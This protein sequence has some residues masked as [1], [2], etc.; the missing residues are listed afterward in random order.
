MH[1][2]SIAHEL[3]TTAED[4]MRAAGVER[5]A[6]VHLRLGAL[7]GVVPEAL[8]FAYAIA[9]ERTLLAGSRLEIETAPVVVYCPTCAAERTLPSIQSFQ[10][11]V[12]AT[13]TADVRQ[14]RE[15]ELIS[16]ECV[17]DETSHT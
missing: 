6:V 11:P 8:L 7:S 10:C 9:A 16:L 3:I 15:I 5:A 12:C 4:A 1:E 14:G 17:D 2:L 13:P